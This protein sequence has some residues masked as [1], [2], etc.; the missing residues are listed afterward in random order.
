MNNT[1]LYDGAFLGYNENVAIELKLTPKHLLAL[2][3]VVD[4][5]MCDDLLVR[6][7]DGEKCI[8]YTAALY[9]EIINAHPIINTNPKTLSKT[10]FANLQKA[11]VLIREGISY[12]KGTFRVFRFGN[13][14]QRLCNL[15]PSVFDDVQHH[16]NGQDCTKAYGARGKGENKITHEIDYKI[17]GYSQKFNHNEAADIEEVF[18]EH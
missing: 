7:I 1:H 11:E 18:C 5:L 3:Y 15:V 9:A 16:S 17:R 8:D 6:L 2:R 12:G 4:N 13:N 14:Y 10:I